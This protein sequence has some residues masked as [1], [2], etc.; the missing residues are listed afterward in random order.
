VPFDA[1]QLTA[2]NLVLIHGIRDG[3][4]DFS[5]YRLWM[6]A[7]QWPASTAAALLVR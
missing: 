2:K 5:G 3:S 1:E 7:I 4:H 6:P